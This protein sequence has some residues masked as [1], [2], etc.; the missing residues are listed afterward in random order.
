MPRSGREPEDGALIERARHGDHEAYAAL[1]RSHQD[2]VFRTAYLITR[3][4]VDAED[5]TQE[6]FI[7]AYRALSTFRQGAP[8]RPWIL[9]IAANEARNRRRAIGRRL[10]V[11]ADAPVELDGGLAPPREPADPD[12]TPEERALAGERREIL[13]AALG[14]L[15]EDDR[16]VIAYRYFFDLSEAEM[17]QAL[18]VPRG[19]VKSRLSRALARLRERFPTAG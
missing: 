4:A 8:F 5:V 13:L 19:T 15:D 6:A 7:K 2:V 3:S 10:E 14:R 9:R 1:V 11:S 12:A 17:S 18:D 16:L